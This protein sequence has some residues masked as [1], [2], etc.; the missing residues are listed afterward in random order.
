VLDPQVIA[1]LLAGQRREKALAALTARERQLL[2]LMAEGHS[3]TAI[4]QQLVLSASAV[5]NTSAA[6]SPSSACTPMTPST[7][8]CWAS[9]PT[10]GLRA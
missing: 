5:E 9:S 2:A 8:G 6:S 1:Q 10:S 3:N 7:A 4:V